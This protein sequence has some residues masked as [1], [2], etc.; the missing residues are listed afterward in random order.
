MGIAGRKAPE[1]W[2][3][4]GFD[5][6]NKTPV[7]TADPRETR[8]NSA[9]FDDAVAPARELE[10]RPGAVQRDTIT[11]SMDKAK[12]V[13]LLGRPANLQIKATWLVRRSLRWNEFGLW[14][15]LRRPTGLQR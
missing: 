7:L 4:T 10:R 9:N 13:P 3:N 15:R 1:D 5:A 12:Q 8:A 14:Q 2:A 6:S 11:G